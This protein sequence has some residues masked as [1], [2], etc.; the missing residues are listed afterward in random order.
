MRFRYLLI[1]LSF[2]LITACGNSNQTRT[3]NAAR[4]TINV[5]LGNEP[6]TLDWSLATDSTS[7]MV[8]NNIM[9]GLTKF[10]D[11][12]TP[13]PDLAESWNISKDGKTYTF[14]IREGV[15]WTDGKP[16]TAGDF[17]YSW[18]RILDPATGGDYAYSL[19]DVENAEDYNTGKIKDQDLV[20]VK[21]LDDNSLV[22]KLRRPASY[23]PSMLAFISTFPER[24]D[25]IENHGQKWTDPENIVT[26][27]PYKLTYW[28]H[29]DNVILT[30]NPGYWGEQPKID[31]VRMIMNENPSSA[32]AQYESDELDY[33]DSKSIPPLEVPRLKDLPDFTTALQ[34]RG[35]YIAFNVKKRPFDNP[36]VRKAFAASIDR[37]SIVYLLQGA[38]ITT[39]SW[40]PKNMLGY[41]PDIGIDFNP[42][43]AREWLKE[44]GY[45]GGKG[46]PTVRFLWPDVSNNRV[47]AEALQSMWKEYLGV[48][49][50]LM[51][52]EWK[53]YLSTIN[54]DPPEIHR[55]G[56]GADFPDP[57]NFMSLFTC[58][59]GNNRTRWCNKEYDTLV[60]KAAQ[61]PDP[62]KRKVLYD[63]A[64]KI[65]LE[66]DA[67]IAP[68]YI[69]NQQ[70]MIKPYVKGLKP[71]PLDLVLYKNVYFQDKV[72]DKKETSK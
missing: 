41:N 20:G 29:H 36:L 51:N 33:A 22:V 55:A 9:E 45:P 69:S 58:Y 2:L 27:G 40:I 15:K 67:P 16:L 11:D 38:G 60:E 23:F 4:D 18:K 8:I 14:K 54:T 63:Q 1:I 65:L 30:K 25:I 31:K 5:N 46:F 21:A 66:T 48:E 68:F 49:V 57:H 72:A 50:E 42:V 70:N 10:S 24:K 61:E 3:G 39:K 26:L 17:E 47:I 32:L 59:S 43:Q 35:N 71:N 13:E 44:A 19:Y 53:V 28:K 56:W 6:P 7:V 64:Q 62:G 37:K 34:F 52:E 12:F